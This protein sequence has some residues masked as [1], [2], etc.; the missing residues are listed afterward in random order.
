MGLWFRDKQ[1][2]DVISVE[3]RGLQ[4]SDGLFE[5]IAIRDGR[6]RLWSLHAERLQAGCHRLAIETPSENELL[7]EVSSAISATDHTSSDALLKIV[8]TRGQGNRGYAPP[9]DAKPTILIGIFERGTCPESNYHD[10]IS[11]RFC[12]AKLASQ[13]QTAGI[14]LLARL[15]QVRARSE[16][17]DPAIVEG[18]MLDQAGSV[19]SGTISNLFIVRD[20]TLMTPEITQCGV[21]GVMRRHILALASEHGTNCE[22]ARLT[23]TDVLSADEVFLCNSQIGIWPVSSCGNFRK[24]DWPLTRNIRTLLRAS[25]VIEGSE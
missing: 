9:T 21:S 25:G 17:D 4:Y 10:G 8:V 15:D 6:P 14:K 11:V 24:D 13:P 1:P 20:H 19:I 18:L 2:C 16:W 3:D 22:L 12:D 5:T 7:G 23:P